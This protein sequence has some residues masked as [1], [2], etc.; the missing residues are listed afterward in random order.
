MIKVI[1]ASQKNKNKYCFSNVTNSLE[2]K[3]KIQKADNETYPISRTS[4]SKK[5]QYFKNSTKSTVKLLNTRAFRARLI[6]S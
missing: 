2:E 3:L 4:P 5:I 1:G 6:Y